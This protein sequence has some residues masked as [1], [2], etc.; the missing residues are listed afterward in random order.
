MNALKPVATRPLLCLSL[1]V[2]AYLIVGYATLTPGEVWGDDWAQYLG[3]A[4]NLALGHPYANT[5][6]VFN[7]AQPHIGP[8]AYPP[9]LPLLMAPLVKLVGIDFIA[10]KLMSLV[11][12]ALATILT[13]VL[14]KDSLGDWVALASAAFFSLHDAI[15]FQHNGIHSYARRGPCA[16]GESWPVSP[17][18]SLRMRLSPRGR[19]ARP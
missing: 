3:H 12:L 7:P 11:A 4:R 15:W 9:G 8:P 16:A 1:L 6:Y 13:F 14:Y 2:A 10:F 17:V 18:A 19:S 5:G